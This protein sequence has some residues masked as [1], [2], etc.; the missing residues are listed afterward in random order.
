MLMYQ[1]LAHS[2]EDH[3]GAVE[4]TQHLFES[5]PWVSVPLA[6]AVMI[7]IPWLVSKLSKSK[8]LP[9]TIGLMEL[10][11][12]GLLTYSV[13]PAL[14]IISIGVGFVLAFAVAF[15]GIVQ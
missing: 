8:S 2:G 12:V 10:F 13:L 11:L 6:L 4:S 7:L 9:L 15:A 14:S 3:Q 1:F 5:D